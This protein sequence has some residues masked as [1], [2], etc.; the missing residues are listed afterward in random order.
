MAN[1]NSH[2][3]I[4]TFLYN[5]LGLTAPFDANSRQTALAWRRRGGASLNCETKIDNDH[6]C[7]L[8]KTASY[9]LLHCAVACVI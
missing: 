9:G 8:S 5:E 4:M 3:F 7:L 6:L 2:E 1:R